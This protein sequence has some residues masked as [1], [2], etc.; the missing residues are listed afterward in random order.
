MTNA[1][2]FSPHLPERPAACPPLAQWAAYIDGT[3]VGDECETMEVHLSHCAACLEMV[4]THRQITG[5]AEPAL[6]LV[7]A[8]VLQRAM[9][10]VGQP[11]VGETGHEQAARRWVVHLR[12]GAAVAACL[13]IGGAGYFVGAA[14]T[15][16]E[17][18]SASTAAGDEF[19]GLIEASEQDNAI[20]DLL[21]IEWGERSS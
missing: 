12:R 1:S 5:E 21:A 17:P 8:H 14:M 4:R 11:E 18:L 13:V 10:L 20:T 7:P 16:A 15:S 3:L 6:T 2:Q 19:F 9:S